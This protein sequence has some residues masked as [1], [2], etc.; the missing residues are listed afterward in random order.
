MI[1][2][3]S[4]LG[5]GILLLSLHTNLSHSQG[6]DFNRWSIEGS[7]GVNKPFTPHTANYKSPTVGFFT[8]GLGTRFMAN[9]KFGIQADFGF[10]QY[11][12]KSGTTPF[13]T[14]YVR[15]SLQGVVSL[16][17]MFE[18]KDWTKSISLLLHAGAGYSSLG[19]KEI[20]IG[21][22]DNMGHL[23]AG[24]TPQ[25]RL[26]D[27]VSLNIDISMLANLSQ[28]RTIDYKTYIKNSTITG[29]TLTGTAGISVYLGKK[30]QHADW[31]HPVNTKDQEI[32]SLKASMK[33]YEEKINELEERISQVETDLV[34]SDGDGVA[35]KYDLEPNTRQGAKVDT[36]GREIKEVILGKQSLDSLQGL[37]YTVQLGVYS[38]EVSAQVMKN[39]TPID[40]KTMP[41]GKIRYF[42][43]VFA[44]QEEAAIKL[45]EAKKAGISDAFMTAYFKGARIT[46]AEA[47]TF[48][49][50]MGPGI[51]QKR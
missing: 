18:F 21:K 39:I 37:F 32:D 34:D 24:L 26:G 16:G 51:L 10:Q 36:K 43:G 28:S 22:G 1:L 50:E 5:A 41:D 27:R 47:K 25:F 17:N 15:G 8:A 4:L 44:S 31:Y 48:L 46:L 13:D 49:Q 6:S 7:F 33:S 40:T 19:D 38:H 12:E 45:D 3:K 42:S 14:K 9:N 20:I 30:K 2:K 23:I 35:D 11:R 29:Y